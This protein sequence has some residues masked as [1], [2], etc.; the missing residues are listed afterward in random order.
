M[1][2]SEQKP[3]QQR[4][5]G[6]QFYM[7]DAKGWVNM[8]SQEVLISHYRQLEFL[9]WLVVIYRS[10]SVVTRQPDKVYTPHLQETDINGH[11]TAYSIKRQV[12]Y[13]HC[14]SHIWLRTFYN[15]AMQTKKEGQPQPPFEIHILYFVC[16]FINTTITAEPLI[17]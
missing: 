6:K 3:I 1:Q 11:V 10:V 2:H 5:H 12:H 14:F 15:L 7:K 16:S 9:L 4:L 17:G 8:K 13:C